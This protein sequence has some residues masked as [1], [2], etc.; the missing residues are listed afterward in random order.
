MQISDLFLLQD[1]NIKQFSPMYVLL[2][3]SVV[4]FLYEKCVNDWS[5]DVPLWEVCE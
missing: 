4:M 5:S 1:K 2:M 3:H